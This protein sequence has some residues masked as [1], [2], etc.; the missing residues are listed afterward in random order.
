[1]KK[2]YCWPDGFYYDERFY[3][4]DPFVTQESLT[5]FNAD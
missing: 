5:N 1:M 3:S 2:H 4:D